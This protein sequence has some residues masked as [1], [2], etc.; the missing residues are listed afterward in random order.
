MIIAVF[1]A[2]V[3]LAALLAVAG[4]DTSDGE[5]WATHQRL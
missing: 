4:T 2:I 1:A 5:D 3:A